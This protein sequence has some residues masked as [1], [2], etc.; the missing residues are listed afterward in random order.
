MSNPYEPPRDISSFDSEFG[1][2][3]G[4]KLTLGQIIFSFDGRIPRKVYWLGSFFTG[5][6][7]L[8]YAF[9]AGVVGALLGGGQAGESIA[10]ILLIPGYVVLIW[11]QLAIQIKR[12]HDRGKSGW[13]IF[14]S[15]I[16]CIGG[17]FVLVET[18]FSRG[19]YGHNQYGPDATHLY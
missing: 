5:A 6:M 17:I 10:T 1:R 7:F 13:W 8:G 19:D 18:G 11:S 9:F 4:G 16:P 2:D 15:L 12:W 14:A 3:S